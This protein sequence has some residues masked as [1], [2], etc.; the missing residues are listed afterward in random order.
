[1]LEPFEKRRQKKL[2]QLEKGADIQ[3]KR[4]VEMALGEFFYRAVDSCGSTMDQPG[5]M[6]TP[7]FQ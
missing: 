3:I 4:P 5:K 6:R 7:F 1:M 2:N